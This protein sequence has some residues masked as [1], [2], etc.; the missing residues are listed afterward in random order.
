MR[1]VDESTLYFQTLVTLLTE[2]ELQLRAHGGDVQALRYRE[3]LVELRSGLNA[4]IVAS[5][6]IL[7]E[8]EPPDPSL[9]PNLLAQCV[10]GVH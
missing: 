5:R 6:Y 7:A 3:L 8:I 2:A 9:A 10:P 4:A 1:K